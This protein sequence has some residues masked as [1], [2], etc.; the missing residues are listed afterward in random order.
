MYKTHKDKGQQGQTNTCRCTN[1]IPKRRPSLIKEGMESH[2]MMNP[3]AKKVVI[4]WLTMRRPRWSVKPSIVSQTAVAAEW[5]GSLG[6]LG[7][8]YRRL[9]RG[10]PLHPRS[11]KDEER[12]QGLCKGSPSGLAYRSEVVW[13]S[14][15]ETVI[16]NPDTLS[17]CSQLDTLPIISISWN[18]AVWKQSLL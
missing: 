2:S 8:W 17:W 16:W 5:S 10:S 13:Y 9:A 6:L 18:L 15:V 11:N 7:Q 4:N 12:R 1:N 14:D 3:Q